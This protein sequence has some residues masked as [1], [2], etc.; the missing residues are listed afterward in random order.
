[1]NAAWRLDPIVTGILAAPLFFVFGSLLYRLYY[2]SFEQHGRDQLRGLAFF[3]GVLFI[4]EVSLVLVFGVDY[5]LVETFYST[6]SFSVGWVGVPL[7]LLVPF[8]ASLVM[9]FGLQLVLDRS[10]LGRAIKAVAQAP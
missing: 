5:R 8:I 6:T 4:T 3:F 9:L 10:F 1:T 2:V 7:R